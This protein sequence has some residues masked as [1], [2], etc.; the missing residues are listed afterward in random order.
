M[1]EAMFNAPPFTRLKRLQQLLDSK[2]LNP[3][4]YWSVPPLTA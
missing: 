2:Q 3:D 1:N 4:F